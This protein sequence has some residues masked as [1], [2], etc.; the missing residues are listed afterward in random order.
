MKEQYL[1]VREFSLATGKWPS[2]VYAMLYAGRIRAIK[3][4]DDQ[5]KIPQSEVARFTRKEAK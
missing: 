5:W 1:S 3:D 4:A 2:Y